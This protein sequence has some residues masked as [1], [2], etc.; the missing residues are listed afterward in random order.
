MMPDP[1]TPSYLIA[2]CSTARPEKRTSFHVPV[3]ELVEPG[4][5]S[6][7]C[8]ICRPLT[9]SSF[10]SRSLTLTPIFAELRSSTGADAVTVTASL[11]PAGF[12]SR[13]IASS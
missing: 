2:F 4:A 12:I 9:G 7:S 10:T 6:I 1:S 8:D 5:C 11:T 13:S 3:P